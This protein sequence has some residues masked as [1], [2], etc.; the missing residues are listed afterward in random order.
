MCIEQ[1]IFKTLLTVICGFMP[2]R[3]QR[4]G[5]HTQMKKWSL[6]SCIMCCRLHLSSPLDVLQT[7]LLFP[8]SCVTC[9]VYCVSLFSIAA[10]A[11]SQCLSEPTILSILFFGGPYLGGRLVHNSDFVLPL[12][13]TVLRRLPYSDSYISLADPMGQS[14]QAPIRSDS[15]TLPYPLFSAGQ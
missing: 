1:L 4:S 10:V 11:H 6:H 13:A 2:C 12:V 14:D 5:G 8:S 3:C 7:V 15:G 9:D